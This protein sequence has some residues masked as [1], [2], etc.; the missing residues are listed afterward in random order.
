MNES[1][2]TQLQ[3]WLIMVAGIGF[4]IWQGYHG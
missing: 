1:Q 2:I 3:Y 4:A